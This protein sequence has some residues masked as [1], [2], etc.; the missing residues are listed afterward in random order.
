MALATYPI[1]PM[2][3]PTAVRLL[4]LR[5]N[6]CPSLGHRERPEADFECTNVCPPDLHLLLASPADLF[7]IA[8]RGL[9]RDDVDDDGEDLG[10]ACQTVVKWFFVSTIRH[11]MKGI[12]GDLKEIMGRIDGKV[13]DPNE[14][15]MLNPETTRTS[16]SSTRDRQRVRDSA[17]I[18]TSATES[19]ATGWS[20]SP[21]SRSRLYNASS[22]SSGR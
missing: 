20:W 4:V 6:T 12:P 9:R 21:D 19:K 11:A 15:Q 14:E 16:Q 3:T 18:S 5:P 22:I 17:S 2:P 7:A 1:V 10:N 8:K 13:R